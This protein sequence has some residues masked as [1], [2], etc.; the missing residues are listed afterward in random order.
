MTPMRL[1]FKEYLNKTLEEKDEY[2]KTL[3]GNERVKYMDDCVT[4]FEQEGDKLI[5]DIEDVVRK[6]RDDSTT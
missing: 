3:S 1:P 6:N 5:E 4:Y 2:L